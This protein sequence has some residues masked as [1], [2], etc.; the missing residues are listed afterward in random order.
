MWQLKKQ[1]A[2]HEMM[3]IKEFHSRK[4]NHVVIRSAG[5]D[6]VEAI[7]AYSTHIL[8]TFLDVVLTTPEEFK[9][10]AEDQ[11]NWIDRHNT[12]PDGFLA[13]AVCDGQII[14]MIHLLAHSKKKAS[15]IGEFALSVRGEY[16]NQEV[17]SELLNCLVEWGK[18]NPTIE[19]VI[20]NVN[21]TNE[22]AI[23]L[24]RKFGFEIEGVN[25]KAVKQSDGRYFDNL[26]MALFV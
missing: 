11:K 6:D 12:S 26:Q 25:K 23:C 4:G 7:I 21:S 19:K 22:K 5:H 13:I 9:P 14:G 1:L 10:T 24:Y 17:G 2:T 16:H 20:L 3:I 18:T 15:H 8:N